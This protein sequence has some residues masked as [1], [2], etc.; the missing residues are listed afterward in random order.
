V[1][2]PPK[3]NLVAWQEWGLNSDAINFGELRLKQAVGI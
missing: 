1:S 2:F 3:N